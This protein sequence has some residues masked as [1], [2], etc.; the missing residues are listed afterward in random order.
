MQLYVHQERSS[1]KYPAKQLRAFGCI[2]LELGQKKTVSFTVR[3]NRLA[4]YDEKIHGFRIEDGTVQL[5]L[6]STS[7][8]I[9]R[10]S[11]FALTR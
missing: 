10:R 1:V 6:G 8:D 9:R 3:A 2:T 4:F 5:M 7:D 11:Q